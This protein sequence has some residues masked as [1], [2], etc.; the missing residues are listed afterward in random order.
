MPLT[1][2]RRR[3]FP[4]PPASLWVEAADASFEHGIGGG[5]GEAAAAAVIAFLEADSRIHKKKTEE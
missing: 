3:T 5:G 2:G 4:P 1:H